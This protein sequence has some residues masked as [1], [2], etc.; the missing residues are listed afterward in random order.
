VVRDPVRRTAKYNVKIDPDSVQARYEG[1]K[2][3][4]VEQVGHRF[5]ELT[6]FEAKAKAILD[7]Y[8]VSVIKIP[9][10]LSWVREVYR[11]IKT[12]PG[13]TAATEAGYL[14]GKWVS[15]GLTDAILKDLVK[16]IF[17]ITLA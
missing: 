14:K 17:G 7:Y 5:P 1:M 10:Y 9:F 2:T 3:V 11:L 6:A 8:G 4:M 16:T 15:R 12:H 13:E